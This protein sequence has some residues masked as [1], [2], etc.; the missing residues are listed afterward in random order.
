[1]A[2]SSII[3]ARAWGFFERLGLSLL[4]GFLFLFWE[5]I[6]GLYGGDLTSCS[7]ESFPAWERI[8]LEARV[9]GGSI[10]RAAWIQ[11]AW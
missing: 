3:R 8:I 1:L 5:Q 7:L 6:L 10:S 2:S 9:T 11:R 4:E